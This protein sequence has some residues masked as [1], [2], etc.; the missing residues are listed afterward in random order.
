[1]QKLLIILMV[2][3][4]L[5]AGCAI[6]KPDIQQGNVVTPEMLEQLK[7]GMSSRQVRFIMGSPLLTDPFHP[8]RWDYIYML[9]KP[10]MNPERKH[11]V[12]YFD[13]D[14]LSRIVTEPTD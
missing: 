2:C 13:N 10:G 12:L 11:T 14:Q 6:H 4:T 8:N 9:T 7:I 5:M 1:M 3:A